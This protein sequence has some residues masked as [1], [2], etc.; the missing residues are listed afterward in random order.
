MGLIAGL[1][2]GGEEVMGRA[3]A[4]SFPGYQQVRKPA[5]NI[6]ILIG[7]LRNLASK[8][9]KVEKFAGVRSVAVH[10]AILQRHNNKQVSE[11]S[12]WVSECSK[13]VSGCN[14]RVIRRNK[15]VSE[16]GKRVVRDENASTS[17]LKQ[18]TIPSIA[19]SPQCHASCRCL[20]GS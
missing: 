16:R 10:R 12:K 9:P 7:A 5:E 4:M 15:W 18:Q 20:I 8:F 17:L 3:I 11:Y 14:K 13:W 2:G 19:V 1:D 6:A